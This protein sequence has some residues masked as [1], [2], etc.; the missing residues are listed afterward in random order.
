M[1]LYRIKQF[2]WSINTHINED[3]IRYIKNILNKDELKLFNRL[4]KNEQ[5]HC[6]RVSRD[7]EGFLFNKGVKN[8]IL[9][10]VALLHDIGKIRKKVNIINKSII[11]I[12]HRLTKGNLKKFSNIEDINIY[13]NHGKIGAQI[14]KEY[15]YNNKFLYLVENHHNTIV[16]SDKELNI[17]KYFDNKN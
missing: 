4:A 6:I 12:L 9:V 2:I 5:K 3:D 8:D 14:L 1:F 17:I 15:G 13:Y 7:V 11:V 16:L 10:K